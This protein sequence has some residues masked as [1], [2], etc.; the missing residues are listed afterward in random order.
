MH[1]WRFDLQRQRTINTE[2][3]VLWHRRRHQHV[4]HMLEVDSLPTAFPKG[5]SRHGV[6]RPPWFL[7][8][9]HQEVGPAVVI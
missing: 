1:I 5:T 3:R 6:A 4:P 2:I 7:L 8:S 9:A